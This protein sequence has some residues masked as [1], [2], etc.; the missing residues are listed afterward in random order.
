[1]RE[2][3]VERDGVREGGCEVDGTDG[4]MGKRGGLVRPRF[5]G[6]LGLA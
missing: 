6:E 2:G 4:V 5:M 1:M 3:W